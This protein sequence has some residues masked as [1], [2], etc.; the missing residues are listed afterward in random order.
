MLTC[1]PPASTHIISVLRPTEA[2]AR[3]SQALANVV[4]R[5]RGPT[6]A[7][8]PNYLTY[9]LREVGVEPGTASTQAEA[10]DLADPL[11]IREVEILRL[12]AARMTN[13][14]IAEQL[15]VSMSTVKK[16]A[17]HPQ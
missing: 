9:P 13:Q 12:V 2:R 4:R 1:T 16:Q 5:G 7:G 17:R 8:S 11:T 3:S 14:K 6:G 15:V 10:V